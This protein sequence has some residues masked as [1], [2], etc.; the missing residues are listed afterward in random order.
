MSDKPK[1]KKSIKKTETKSSIKKSETKSS[2]KGKNSKS[3]EKK[4]IT[5]S[6]NSLTHSHSNYDN[7]STTSKI[8]EDQNTLKKNLVGNNNILSNQINNINNINNMY[9]I[10]NIN[11]PNLNKI[12]NPIIEKCEGCFQG[13]GFY[14]CQNCNKIYCKICDDQLHIIPS[15][16]NHERIEID[17]FTNLNINC[18]HHNLP[19]RY[20]CESCQEPIC[21]NCK[22]LGPHNNPLHHVYSIFDIYRKYI[23]NCKVE[24]EKN[25]LSKNENIENILLNIESLSNEN[26]KTANLILKGINNEYDSS[27]NIIKKEEGK[28]LAVLNFNSSNIQKEIIQIE[29]LLNEISEEEENINPHIKKKEDPLIF[30]LKY[31]TTLKKIDKSISKTNKNSITE[32]DIKKLNNWPNELNESKK[33]IDEYPKIK[34]LLKIKEDMIWNLITIPYEDNSE[35]LKKIKEKAEK[36]I[37]EWSKLS[38]KYANELKKYNLVCPF[39]GIYLDGIKVNEDCP[40]N[41]TIEYIHSGLT[42]EIPPSDFYGN[43]RHFFGEPVP[44]FQ[45]I[46]KD[47]IEK[48]KI[49]EINRLKRLAKKNEIEDEKIEEKEEI[50]EED[51]NPFDKNI[52][53]SILKD[54]KKKENKRYYKQ[55]ITN[56]WVYK[57]AGSIEKFKINLYQ[58][59]SDV[60]SDYD[61]FITFEELI[62]AFYKM[63]IYLTE[64]DKTGLLKYLKLSEYKD[65]SIDILKFT[66]NFMREIGKEEQFNMELKRIEKRKTLKSSSKNKKKD[67]ENEEKKEFEKEINNNSIKDSNDE[68]N[69]KIDI[70]ISNDGKEIKPEINI[71]T[72]KNSTNNINESLNK[73]N[74]QSR[75]DFKNIIHDDKNE[76]E[77]PIPQNIDLDALNQN[78][79]KKNDENE[80]GNS[81]FKWIL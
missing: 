50:K 54:S 4:S 68:I 56:D 38:D 62:E 66:K 15:F 19:L 43:K 2:K 51:K 80:E 3:K 30:L 24:I 65:G 23:N 16:K 9:N 57:L 71:N 53:S 64:G 18:Y 67:F 46:V 73:S 52:L 20:F 70:K 49:E 61:G 39:C 1:K 41:N 40:L 37:A 55:T 36:E 8:E 28:K 6:K 76:N 69:T 12:N 79:N 60:D 34:K 78:F 14:Y 48:R 45:E 77:F 58:V 11:N 5:K 33:Q 74:R 72:L 32:E 31:K 17:N 21:F 10:N 29:N 22:N 59:L 25:L 26:K 47:I 13:E 81:E 7:K 35:E 44:N 42:I 75:E 27:L 63:G